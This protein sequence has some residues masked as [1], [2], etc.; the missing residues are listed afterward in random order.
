MEETGSFITIKEGQR[1]EEELGESKS[2]LK[3]KKPEEDIFND[4]MNDIYPRQMNKSKEKTHEE[5]ARKIKELEEKL[6]HISEDNRRR[7]K[8]KERIERENLT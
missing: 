3:R 7:S 6:E 1:M 8:E 2:K 4:I 5:E